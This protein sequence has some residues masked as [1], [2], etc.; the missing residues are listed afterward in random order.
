[1]TPRQR[2]G[3]A[4]EQRA[5]DYLTSRGHVLLA[6]N[7]RVRSGELDLVLQCGRELVVVEVR[8]R[9]SRAFGGAA[10]SV[11]PAKRARVRRAAQAFLF[12]RFGA[13]A[14]PAVR[15]DVVAIDG[16]DIDWIRAAF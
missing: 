11:T 14:W 1:M 6:R 16:T 12:E 15:F 4:A 8:Q 2:A 13:A 3:R 10:A 9:A 5:L 7:F